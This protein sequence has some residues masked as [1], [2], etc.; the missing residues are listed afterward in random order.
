M[1][2]VRNRVRT[3][4]EH[5]QVGRAGRRTRSGPLVIHSLVVDNQTVEGAPEPAAAPAP[6]VGFVVGR[7][8]G[9]AVVRN[10]V[11]RR[12]R[13]QVRARLDR[14]PAGTLMIVRALP[15]GA[16]ASSDELGRALDRGLRNRSAR[17]VPVAGPTG[18]IGTASPA[19]RQLR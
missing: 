1:L 3:R 17:L 13:E 8:V 15:E 16:T 2:P 4:A 11:R 10:R 7:K 12:L 18:V 19:G 9:N 5:A 6:R 14:I